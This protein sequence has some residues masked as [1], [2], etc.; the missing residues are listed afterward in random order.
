[1]DADDQAWQQCAQQ[2]MVVLDMMRGSVNVLEALKYVGD[3]SQPKTLVGRAMRLAKT[4]HARLIRFEGVLSIAASGTAAAKDQAVPVVGADVAC[5]VAM[6]ALDAARMD[7]ARCVHEETQRLRA[8]AVCSGTAVPTSA[9]PF[10]PNATVDDDQLGD[11]AVPNCLLEVSPKS[12]EVPA[13][14]LLVQTTK[15]SNRYTV[16]T[17]QAAQH[18]CQQLEEA[19]TT[20]VNKFISEFVPKFCKLFQ[21]WE[22]L[23]SSVG[24]MDVLHAF[25]LKMA[26]R[27]D[28][29][30][31]CRPRVVPM[32]GSSG[33]R[34]TNTAILEVQNGWYPLARPSY[35][36]SL[37]KDIAANSF[38][39]GGDS[40]PLM[41]LTGPN[42]GG[43]STFLRLACTVAFLA[44]VG[45]WVPATYCLVTPADN[46]YTRMGASD[47]MMS[48]TSTFQEEMME[49]ANMLNHATCSS[50]VVIDELGRGTSTYDGCAIAYATLHHLLD[51]VKARA[52][53]ATHHHALVREFTNKHIQIMHMAARITQGNLYCSY[54]LRHGPAPHGSCGIA[55]AHQAGLPTQLTMVASHV[56]EAIFGDCEYFGKASRGLCLD[57]ATTNFG[58]SCK[59]F[60]SSNDVCAQLAT[61]N[62]DHVLQKLYW[63]QVIRGVALVDDM[64]AGNFFELWNISNESLHQMQNK[65]SL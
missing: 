15:T 40:S 25:A 13:E 43:K 41:L 36:D 27:Q 5:D 37:N 55:V 62:I 52:L 24:D 60:A 46:I 54:T 33:S 64:W 1:M 9:R 23:I 10:Y 22:A 3:T 31:W 59:Y 12:T 63:D 39:L 49:T 65:G 47:N 38:I 18:A 53:F 42:M 45:C 30:S 58:T 34:G 21:L 19:Y 8:H 48:G 50:L 26:T 56:A 20:A 2:L 29:S 35:G 11:S 7:R 28:G 6:Q 32:Q 51:R 17:V 57:A 61:S 44:Q 16:P 4:A 14:Y